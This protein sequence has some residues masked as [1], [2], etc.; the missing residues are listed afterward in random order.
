MCVI[1][2]RYIPDRA[3]PKMFDRLSTLTT[4][5]GMDIKHNHHGIGSQ[6]KHHGAKLEMTQASMQMK[7]S[8]EC[9]S[10]YYTHKQE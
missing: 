6:G 1:K 8:L 5:Q 2:A 10:R 3:A 9:Q 7:A 4:L